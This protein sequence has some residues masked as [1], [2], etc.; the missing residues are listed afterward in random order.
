[1]SLQKAFEYPQFK[2]KSA[3]QSVF[4]RGRNFYSKCSKCLLFRFPLPHS[5][6]SMWLSVVKWRQRREKQSFVVCMMVGSYLNLQL[7]YKPGES[8]VTEI[9]SKILPDRQCGNNFTAITEYER[10]PSD[11]Q[12][13][14][15][16]AVF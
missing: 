3:F 1:M 2:K 6:L 13:Y 11:F 15:G 7:R 9:E 16:S 4:E 8:R 10:M 12:R 5:F 14:R